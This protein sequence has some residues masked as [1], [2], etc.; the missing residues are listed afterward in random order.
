MEISFGAIHGDFHELLCAFENALELAEPDVPGRAMEGAVFLL[1]DDDIDGATE[2][3][4]RCGDGVNALRN[5][6]P[7]SSD[8]THFVKAKTRPFSFSVLTIYEM[9]KLERFVISSQ[10]RKCP[11]AENPRKLNAGG[12]ED[13]SLGLKCFFM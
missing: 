6:T 9:W 13:E 4:E 10:I 12:I 5:Q 2:G 3:V 1:D 8:Q 7:E 11:A